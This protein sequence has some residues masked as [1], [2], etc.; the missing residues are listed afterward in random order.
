MFIS[1]NNRR[2]RILWV[3]CNKIKTIKPIIT[4]TNIT[5]NTI[6]FSC[7]SLKYKSNICFK[8]DKTYLFIPNHLYKK[9]NKADIKNNTANTTVDRKFKINSVITI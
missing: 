5:S 7:K 2:Q 9:Y 6:C 8:P 1:K 4:N 3:K